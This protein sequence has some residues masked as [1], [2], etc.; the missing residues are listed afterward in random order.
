MSHKKKTFRQEIFFPGTERFCY[1]AVLFRFFLILLLL[2]CLLRCK[3]LGNSFT[4][5]LLRLLLNCLLSGW[6]FYLFLGFLGRILV[7]AAAAA[8]AATR[9]FLNVFIVYHRAPVMHTEEYAP[10]MIPTING[11]A[12]SLIEE[13]PIT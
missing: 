2:C 13:T 7:E 11:A 1:S 9:F 5:F 12:N 3:T 10:P 4:V 8:G 6:L